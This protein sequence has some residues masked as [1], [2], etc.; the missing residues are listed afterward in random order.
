ME[1]LISMG[2][3]V[4]NCP[5][6]KGTGWIEFKDEKGYDYVRECECLEIM[7][8]QRRLKAS[9][10]SEEFLKKGFK[11]FDDRGLDVLKQ[12][13]MIGLDYCKRFPEIRD[14]RFNSV[15]Y[16]GQVGSGK[17]HLSMA[18]SNALMEKYKVGVIYMPY[19][20]EVTRIKQVVT[21][22]ID[23]NKAISKFKTAQV[24]MIDDLL[25]GKNT[26]ADVNILFEII[27]YRYLNNMPMI[28]STEKTMDELLDFDEGTMSRVIEMARGH[29]IE[30]TGREYNYR[31]RP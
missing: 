23:Y 21:D 26:E 10:I 5:K 6:C 28:I 14:T 18:I 20:E 24:L 31:L 16:Q 19:R 12:A 30:I 25:K 11:N 9:G 22:E 4:E 3:G 17:T 27:N 8:A 1:I 15:L 7:K 29:R 13:K 2:E